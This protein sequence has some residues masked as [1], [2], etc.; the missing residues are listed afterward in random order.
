MQSKGFRFVII[1]LLIGLIGT[2]GYMLVKGPEKKIGI[3]QKAPDFKLENLDGKQVSLADTAGKAKLVYFFYST[4]PDVCPATTFTISK[5]QNKLIEKG[6]FGSKTAIMSISFDPKNDTPEQLKKFSD[7][8]H[9]DYKGW[10]FLRG[11]ES[12]VF[13]LAKKFGV[14]LV[15]DPQ[16][17]AFTHSNL[18]LLV[19][20][21]GN[22]RTYYDGNDADV[23]IDKIVSDLIQISKE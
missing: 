8:Y 9:A 20:G 19:D 22:L 17:G 14:L 13:D 18:I 15:K 23:N 4:C 11:E 3:L 16:T 21:K 5:I 1:L 12:T 7:S 10:Y 2:L 6:V